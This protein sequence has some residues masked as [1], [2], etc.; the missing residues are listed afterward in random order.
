M[1]IVKIALFG[2]T[3]SVLILFMKSCKSEWTFFI[4]LAAGT[5]LAV[6]LLGFLID[7]SEILS[8]W[9][10]YLGD[11][12]DYMGILWKAL[13]ITYLCEFA[14][15]VCKDS[16]NTLIAGQIELCGKVAVML[17]GMPVL[18][19]LLQTVTGYYGG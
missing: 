10:Q 14:S 11:V 5:L 18:W 8:T 19:A 12:S 16:G 4:S 2:V 17:L 3:A 13:G 6:Y 7:L 1:D 9:E 15:G